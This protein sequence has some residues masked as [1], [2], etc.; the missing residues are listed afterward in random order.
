MLRISKSTQNIVT[1]KLYTKEDVG[2]DYSGMEVDSFVII[3]GVS[4]YNNI[5]STKNWLIFDSDRSYMGVEF[6]SESDLD[7]FFIQLMR[8]IKINQI[9]NVNVDT[10][11][12]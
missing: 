10:K 4:H 1:L 3:P 8:D 11:T 5:Y 9:T 6:I 12:K 2:S 7:R